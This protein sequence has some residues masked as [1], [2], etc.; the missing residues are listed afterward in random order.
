MDDK[1]TIHHERVYQSKAQMVGGA[2]GAIAFFFLGASCLIAAPSI[3]QK[4]AYGAIFLTVSAAMYRYAQ[5]KLMATDEGIR[6]SNPWSRYELCWE[7]ID[8]FELGRWKV[9]RAMCRVCTVE[10]SIRPVVGI[11]E[12]NFSAGSAGRMVD[13][14]N[15]ELARRI[16]RP[17]PTAQAE[18][19]RTRA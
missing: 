14:L 9:N 17:T 15:D 2:F 5:S 4:L 16:P 19:F 18:L 8:H 3:A 10:G 1:M 11:A 12:G 7:Q 6:V 13:E